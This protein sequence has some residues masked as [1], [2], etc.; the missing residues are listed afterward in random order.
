MRDALRG[1]AAM[2]GISFEAS[3]WRSIVT[4]VVTPASQA[5]FSFNALFLAVLTDAIL[6]GD[7]T[8]AVL[9]AGAIAVAIGIGS[10][11]AL[12]SFVT[13]MN[14]Q[15]RTDLVIDQRLI[16]LTAGIPRSSTTSDPSTSTGSSSSARTAW[17]S[18]RSSAGSCSTSRTWCRCR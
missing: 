13:R 18:T 8:R 1:M 7:R 16:E 5:L 15:E 12:V 14:L 4:F 10:A 2:I 9:G 3:R 17:R 11:A 6:A